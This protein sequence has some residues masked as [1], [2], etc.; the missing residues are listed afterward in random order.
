MAT[1]SFKQPIEISHCGFAIALPD[2]CLRTQSQ[3]LSAPHAEKWPGGRFRIERRLNGDHCGFELIR[4]RE[5]DCLAEEGICVP[6]PQQQRGGEGIS[7]FHRPVQRKK[8][9]AALRLQLNIS[10]T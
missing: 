2:S 3:K 10:R 5:R 6:W 8:R 7:S 9:A 1:Q 4:F